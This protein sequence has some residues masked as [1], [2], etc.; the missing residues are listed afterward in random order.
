M[1]LTLF[2]PGE[3]LDKKTWS[4]TCLALY[5][6]FKKIDG[7]KPDPINMYA[8]IPKYLKGLQRMYGK[9]FFVGG[10]HTRNR[11]IYP[12]MAMKVAK[13][14][15]KSENDWHLFVA[16]HACLPSVSNDKKCAVFMDSEYMVWAPYAKGRAKDFYVNYYDK[17]T[18]ESLEQMKLIFTE[19]DWT[20]DFLIHQRHLPEEKVI[21]VA[22]GINL[23]PYLGEKDYCKQNLLIVLR[24]G[25]EKVKGLD[26][27]LEAFKIVKRS[28]PS[29]RLSVVGS[30]MGED[31]E[32]VDTYF[33]QPRSVTVELFK[34]S[35]L[36]VMPSKMEPQGVTYVEALANKSP[37]IGLNHFT[38]PEFT[39]YGKYG[40]ICEN[41]S[42]EGL[43]STIINALNKPNLLADMGHRGQ[44]YVLNRY[45]WNHVATK[46][47]NAMN[48]YDKINSP[49]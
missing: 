31:Q 11:L 43:A 17:K 2:T 12:T 35:T 14:I 36:Y 41:E 9:L 44:Q 26:L 21:N 30:K 7:I 40:F 23:K 5:N 48:Q 33:N 42:P 37:I 1:N 39:D 8:L 46:I 18:Q 28:I 38:F 6:S 34:Q 32:G 13:I 27:L 24:E 47:I 10:N 19:N 4:G 49:K 29:C 22:C 3:C 20:R 25:T 45:S 16:D 15:Q